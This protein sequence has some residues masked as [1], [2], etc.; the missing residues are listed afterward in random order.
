MNIEE[1]K[2]LDAI[3]L[4]VEIARALGW[5]VRPRDIPDWIPIW[6]TESRDAIHRLAYALVTDFPD[7]VAQWYIEFLTHTT[8]GGWN[9]SIDRVAWAT[10]RQ[11]CEAYLLTRQKFT[12]RTGTNVV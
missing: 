8:A 6:V 11:M 1:I 3:E 4:D 10:P 12:E 7:G 9:H 2:K 5:A